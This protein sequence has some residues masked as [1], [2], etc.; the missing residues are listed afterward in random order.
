MTVTKAIL[1][2]DSEN[3]MLTILKDQIAGLYQK[4]LT[5]LRELRDELEKLRAKSTELEKELNEINKKINEMESL[6]SKLT[7]NG[8]SLK[9]RMKI[10]G[11]GTA[12]SAVSAAIASSNSMLSQGLALLSLLLGIITVASLVMW[13]RIREELER[14]RRELDG[15]RKQHN[16]KESNK[17]SIEREISHTES[18]IRD[19]KLPK[20]EIKHHRL[21]F[22]L[23]LKK[24]P[25]T[26]TYALSVPWLDGERKRF[27]LVSDV[28]T[29]HGSLES[30]LRSYDLYK[31]LVL[32]EKYL[33]FQVERDL[34]SKKLW[35]DVISSRSLEGFVLKMVKEGVKKIE[36]SLKAVDETV[37][38]VRPS[39]SDLKIIRRIIE[40]SKDGEPREV[41]QEALKNI[42]R[43]IEKLDGLI[44][45]SQLFGEFRDLVSSATQL[46]EK[47]ESI[48]KLVNRSIKDLIERALP[49]ENDLLSFIY[50][51]YFCKDCAD[52][53]VKNYVPQID[54]KGWVIDNVLGGVDQDEDIRNPSELV[55]SKV[56]AVWEEIR[57]D[58]YANLPL[59]MVKDGES[60]EERYREALRR[61]ALPL[62][63][64][65]EKVSLRWTRIFN[66]PVM[67]CTKCGSAL[68]P[69]RSYILY[70]LLLPSIRGYV[71]L[72][73]EFEEILRDKAKDIASVIN[74]ARQEK[75]SRKTV[76]EEGYEQ[77]RTQ[78]ETKLAEQENL[79]KELSFHEQAIKSTIS[80][81]LSIAKASGLS[82]SLLEHLG[83]EI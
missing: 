53:E 27:Y 42:D 69:S 41:M 7:M 77:I 71:M 23:L 52:R 55:S 28:E 58:L 40:V 61:Y 24:N 36:E 62:T 2:P 1:D 25:L 34:K 80:S 17:T 67:V 59:P 44:R 60:D 31:D 29:I 14:V 63:D 75:D 38:V 81:A 74:Q 49:L 18:K 30:L 32:R 56:S 39:R 10:L 21:Y 22:P 45:L 26:Q 8:N 83:G 37:R 43:E 19:F 20:L 68:S 16:E 33:G 79:I 65:H 5:P 35:E 12:I 11:A 6:A 64:L 82:S 66:P 15:L 57:K 70:N 13:R 46:E 48:E 78:Y 4:A 51:T 50:Y 9:R 54:L 3:D 72:L 47:G 76:L 73:S